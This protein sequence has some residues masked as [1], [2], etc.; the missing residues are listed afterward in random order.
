MTSETERG[1]A[2]L[3]AWDAGK[4]KN[5]FSWDRNL[6]RVLALRM[7][8]ERFREERAR[9]TDA[10]SMV[11]TRLS[12]LASVTNHDAN[13]PRLERYDGLGAR[14]ESVVFHPA[15]H[16]AGKLIWQTGVLADY[17]TPGKETLQM[18]LLYLFAQVGEVG[19]LCPLACTAGMIKVIDRLGTD[20]QKKKYLPGLFSRDYDTRIHASQFLT[21]VQGGSD[22]GTNAVVARQEDGG[23]RI[24]GEKWFCSVIDAQLFLMTARPEGAPP[25]TRGLG[26]FVVPRTVNGETNHFH[27]R[28]LKQKLG[29]RAMAS[30][31]TDFVGAWAEPV[32][33][34]ERGFKNVVEHVLNTS[35]LYNAM[36]CAGSMTSAYREAASYARH[37]RAFGDVIGNYPL[38]QDSIANLR[39]DAL[40]AVASSFRLAAQADRLLSA[41]NEELELAWRVGIN[42][43]KYWTSVRNTQCIRLAMEVLGGNGAIETFSPLV[44]LYRDSMVLESWEGTHNVL[45]QQVM[46][47]SARYG[48]H[49][50]FT[51]ELR[52]ALAKC[53]TVPHLHERASRGLDA[54]DGGFQNL[55]KGEGDQRFGR[56]LVDQA[57]ALLQ[58]VALL[59]ELH[60][61][62]TD[63]AK[64]A[65]TDNLLRRF[66]KD[67]LGVPGPTPSELLTD[68]L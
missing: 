35:R 52:G 17:A 49:T 18:A 53:K 9:L 59:E 68:G 12:E 43:N 34:L 65:A 33:E 45:V 26:L 32:G 1:R 41:P 2:D 61:D 15:Y 20:E 40:G 29:T 54:L 58:V 57:A 39:S 37:R 44:R 21:E 5:Y 66:V 51:K 23:Y 67:E 14:T 10:G 3:F 47:D 4:P 8:E 31:E 36:V 25:G 42:V 13:L 28:R 48:A 50:A 46:K 16:E 38:V 7:G 62:P 19:H 64:A 55:A 27:V 22:V 6:G 60:A 24:Y 11:A 30:G 56:V 63:A